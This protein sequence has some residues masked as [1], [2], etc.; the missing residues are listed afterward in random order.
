MKGSKFALNIEFS[1]KHSYTTSEECLAVIYI[2]E[3]F[4]SYVSFLDYGVRSGFTDKQCLQNEAMYRY[5]LTAE[6]TT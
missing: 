6:D 2:F 1:P 5:S 4:A 3:K